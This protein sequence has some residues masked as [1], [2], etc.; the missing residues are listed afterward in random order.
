[1][2]VYSLFDVCTSYD[3]PVIVFVL[4]DLVQIIRVPV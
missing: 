3:E 4:N 1:M 2:N